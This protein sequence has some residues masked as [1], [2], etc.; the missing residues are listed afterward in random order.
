MCFLEIQVL[1]L[2]KFD[3]TQN[4]SEQ[5]GIAGNGLLVTPSFV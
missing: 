5:R 2:E 3:I 4:Y 1:S